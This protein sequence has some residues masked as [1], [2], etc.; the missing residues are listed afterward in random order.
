[1]E[2]IHPDFGSMNPFLQE[3][4]QKN[5]PISS[6]E[7][8]KSGNSRFEGIIPDGLPASI[9]PYLADIKPNGASVVFHIPEK[10]PVY[11]VYEQIERISNRRRIAAG[12]FAAA[13]VGGV[14]GIGRLFFKR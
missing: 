5:Q 12:L 9:K 1:M 6:S 7:G 13:L 2:Q 8:F 3:Q 4:P 14:I 10:A 11:E